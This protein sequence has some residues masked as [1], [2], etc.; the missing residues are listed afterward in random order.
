MGRGRKKA[1][2]TFSF[3][4]VD[5]GDVSGEKKKR[6]LRVRVNNNNNNNKH[7]YRANSM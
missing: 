2:T 3:Y 5:F 6:P 4:I 7:L 1:P